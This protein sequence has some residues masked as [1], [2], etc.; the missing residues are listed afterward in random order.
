MRVSFSEVFPVNTFWTG[1][2]EICHVLEHI[3]PDCWF[4][5]RPAGWLS[6]RAAVEDENKS[7]SVQLN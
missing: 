1:C 7:N 5:G 2:S 3:F 6:G 4:G